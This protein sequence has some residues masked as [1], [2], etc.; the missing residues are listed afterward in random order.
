MSDWMPLEGQEAVDALM[1]AFDRFH[2]S[3]L[4]ETSLATETYVHRDGAMATPGH[5]DTSLILFFQSQGAS[6]QAIELRC[7]GVSSFRFTATSDNRDSIITG[8]EFSGSPDAQRLGLFFV[9]LPLIGP[10]DGELHR[11]VADDEAPAVEVIASRMA[12]RPI[13]DALGPRLRHRRAN[14]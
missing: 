8:C 9:G 6:E 7:D 14:A 5:L 10:P 11:S 12:W 4:R 13:R 2:D 3:C 1:T